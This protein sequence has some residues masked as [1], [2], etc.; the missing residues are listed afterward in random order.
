MRTVLQ[1]LQEVED[2][3]DWLPNNLVSGREL[4]LEDIP[5]GKPGH[6]LAV[7]GTSLTDI[8]NSAN[9]VL[10]DR[11]KLLADFSITCPANA[12]I[13]EQVESLPSEPI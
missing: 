9:Q 12:T 4:Y 13:Q 10:K 5:E 11:R 8:R 7:L 6:C 1:V 3:R 2:T